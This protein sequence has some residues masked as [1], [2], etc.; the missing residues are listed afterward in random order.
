MTTISSF[1]RSVGL[2]RPPIALF[3]AFASVTG[4]LLAPRNVLAT[5]VL[6][7]LAVFV[8]AAGASALNQ[9]Q[10]RR[11][12]AL[13]E[14]TRK[15]PLPVGSISPAHA[16]TAA[17]ALIISGW[18]LL[19]FSCGTAALFLGMFAVLWYNGLYTTLKRRTAF[20]AVPGALVGA[21]PPAIGWAAGG[22][23]L[24][25]MR[26]ISL[27]LLFFLWQVPHFWLLVLSHGEEYE[28]AGLPSLKRLLNDRQIARISF[29]WMFATAAATL[30]LP[31]FGLATLPMV[32]FSLVPA[33]IW[34]VWS[35]SRLVRT[36]PAPLLPRSAFRMINLYMFMVMLLLSIDGL[37]SRTL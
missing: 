25:D 31:L 24:A 35:G 14:R 26:I 28:R 15:R 27:G 23:G 19:A 10:E 22:G 5:G 37:L 9:Y 12:D 18:M 13:M 7:A 36:Q 11:I 32:H 34:L 1:N 21:I 20:A 3:A 17:C 4:Y 16:L 30:A 6:T 2:C 33:A 29:T 8:L